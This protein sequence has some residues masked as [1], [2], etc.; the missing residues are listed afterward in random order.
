MVSIKFVVCA[1]LVIAFAFFITIYHPD[2][3]SALARASRTH[4]QK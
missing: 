3:G 1:F 4:Q 2:D